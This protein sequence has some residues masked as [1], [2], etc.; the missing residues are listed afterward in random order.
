V[1]VAGST[2]PIVR[3][4]FR[5]LPVTP[6][7]GQPWVS[8][9]ELECHPVPPPRGL[10]TSAIFETIHT[11]LPTLERECRR[12]WAAAREAEKGDGS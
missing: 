9:V 5:L 8:A 3:L 12:E 6:P 4:T 2:I 7:P 11:M 1:S 10:T